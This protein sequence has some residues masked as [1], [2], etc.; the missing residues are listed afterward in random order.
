MNFFIVVDICN[1]DNQCPLSP[2]FFAGRI[3]HATMP[4]Q[5]FLLALFS[6][7]SLLAQINPSVE[8]WW[9]FATAFQPSFSVTLG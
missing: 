9:V 8:L 2:V 5:R 4:Y 3:T 6:V 7:C 1:R